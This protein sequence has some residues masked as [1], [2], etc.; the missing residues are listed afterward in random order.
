[1]MSSPP[2]TFLINKMSHLKSVR[3]PV[4][5]VDNLPW[6]IEIAHRDH[7]GKIGGGENVLAIHLH[8]LNGLARTGW[9]CAA[10]AIVELL[11]CDENCAPLSNVIGPWVFNGRELKWSRITFIRWSELFD[12]NAG[13]IRNDGMRFRIQIFAKKLPTPTCGLFYQHIL[14]LCQI[15]FRIE[16][17]RDLLAA[18]SNRF[19]FSDLYWKI[20]VRK[21]RFNDESY[22]GIIL[23]CIPMDRNSMQFCASKYFWTRKIF[24]E[25]R[26]NSERAECKTY[27]FDEPK[28][29]TTI[30]RCHGTS[31]FIK[32]YNLMDPENGYIKNNYISLTVNI[33]D[34]TR[35]DDGNTDNNPII[36]SGNRNYPVPWASLLN[37]IE[38]EGIGANEQEDDNETAS[39]GD[40]PS[41]KM[42]CSICLEN[43]VGRK[44]VSTTCG[45]VFCSEC[46][47]TSLMVRLRCP[48]CQTY[49]G[50]ADL[51]PLYLP[52]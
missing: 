9:S 7:S 37:L 23:Y 4:V 26:L 33:R 34:D 14:N 10:M 46:I 32:W 5:Y 18:D 35:N 16:N 52:W 29:F 50:S 44:V 39:V 24:A 13:Y 42:A 2:A 40:N 17:V 6:Q 22:L 30:N 41:I 27:R 15:N 48:N 1:M 19:R 51:H 38:I 20:V 8:S 49:V 25:F 3:L 43:M 47:L 12:Q 36:V 31:K 21:N 11:T 45:H 28:K